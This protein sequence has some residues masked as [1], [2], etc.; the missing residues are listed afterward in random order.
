MKD[1]IEG[2]R[3]FIREAAGIK[4]ELYSKCEMTIERDKLSI[5]QPIPVEISVELWVKGDGQEENFEIQNRLTK[6]LQMFLDPVSGG[7]G[8]GW[9]IG[10][11]AGYSTDSY[12]ASCVCS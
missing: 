2:S 6:M 9:Q 8:S 7:S 1:F 5:I 11:S 10:M 4:G 3:S 12:E